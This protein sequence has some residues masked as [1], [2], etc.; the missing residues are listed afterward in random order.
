M[1]GL[2]ALIKAYEQRGLIKGLRVARVAP[3]VT[4]LF[5][6]D[7]SYIYCQANKEEATQVMEIL[8]TF[9]RASGQKINTGKSSVF[10]SPNVEQETKEDVLSTLGFH[11]AGPNTQYLGL[12][13]C[14]SRNKT[15]VFGYLKDRVRD[16]VQSWDDSLLNKSGKEILIKTV[17]QAIP[18]YA[19][20][21]F[22]LPIETCKEI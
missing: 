21:V 7:D 18:T 15:T 4:H 20:S 14:M 12:P 19:M 22:L 9:E 13:N 3:T 17:A 8:K 11:E 16:R 1:E 5:F 6:A 10:F 2:S